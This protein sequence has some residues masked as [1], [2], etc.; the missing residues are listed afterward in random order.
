MTLMIH[1]KHVWTASLET[2]YTTNADANSRRP[3]NHARPDSS[4]RVLDPAPRIK[5]RTGHGERSHN[6][7]VEKNQRR[8]DQQLARI[9]EII[10]HDFSLFQRDMASLVYTELL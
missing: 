2:L 1:A 8:R 6:P 10:E 4:A 5:E 3:Q 7:R 9:A